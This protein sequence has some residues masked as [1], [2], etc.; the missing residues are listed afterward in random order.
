MLV[1]T[2]VVRL[3]FKSLVESVTTGYMALALDGK[4][5]HCASMRVEGLC[6]AVYERSL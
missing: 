2:R 1:M 5:E 3:V 4:W 6:H